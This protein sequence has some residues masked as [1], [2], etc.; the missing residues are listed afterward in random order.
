MP[1]RAANV[2]AIVSESHRLVK[3]GT[4]ENQSEKSVICNTKTLIGG[5]FITFDMILL[6]SKSVKYVVG[7][8]V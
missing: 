5:I 6:K 8:F 7:K 1:K 4:D 2:S 3:Y